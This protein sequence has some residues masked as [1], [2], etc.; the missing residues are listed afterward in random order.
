M[1][2][3][4]FTLSPLL[5]ALGLTVGLTGCSDSN[6]VSRPAGLVPPPKRVELAQ[7]VYFYQLVF[8]DVA[9]GEPINEA[10]QVTLTGPAVDAGLV[11]D[12]NNVSLKGKTLTTDIG[13]VTVAAKYDATNTNFSVLVGNA[14]TG[15][16]QTGVEL[17][18]ETSTIGNQTLVIKLV[19]P[20]KAAA[21]NTNT[22]L[23]LAV[24]SSNFTASATG[25]ISDSAISLATAD[26]SSKN[27]AGDLENIGIATIDLPAGVNALDASG[28]KISL[29]GNI[30]ASTVKFGNGSATSMSAFPGGFTPTVVDQ[31][32]QTNNTGAF[33]TGGFAQFNL[34]DSNGTAIKKFDQDVTLSIDLPKTSK[35][36]DGTALLAGDSYPVWSYDEATGNW[37]FETNGLISEK[38]PVD[39]D[40]FTVSFKSKHL[41]YWNLDFLGQTCTGTLNLGRTTLDTR[42]LSV[43]LVGVSGSRFY[44]SF[45]DVR[46][47]QQ[48]FARYPKDMLVNIVV[49]DERNSI[50]SRSTVPQNLCNTG[51]ISIPAPPVVP[52]ASLIVNVTE[53][54]PNGESRRASPTTVAFYD[55]RRWYAGYARSNPTSNVARVSLDGMPSPAQ[56]TLYVFNPLTGGYE[57]QSVTVNAPS[58]T[59]TVNLPNLK[60]QAV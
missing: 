58:T 26:K 53:S 35:K 47:Q 51:T 11:V 30:T 37:Q 14:T 41:S 52:R 24:V 28:N 56:G 29:A 59:T 55:G 8:E 25:A 50:I 48:T 23:A 10:L 2:T 38:T 3:R 6:S 40:N 42:P 60:C 21:V 31:A 39:P 5:I 7:D 27:D 22:D 15:W 34:T 12:A 43:E 1:N 45:Y 16:T 20:K 46:D 57:R 36:L 54:C 17:R 49:R 4:A 9:T 33:I 18:K 32:G 19:N 44:Q 13:S